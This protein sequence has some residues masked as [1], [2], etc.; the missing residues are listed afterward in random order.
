[1]NQTGHNYRFDESGKKLLED[2]TSGRIDRRSTIKKLFLLG[3]TAPAVYSLLGELPQSSEAVAQPF[4]RS[5]FDVDPKKINFQFEQLQKII[6]SKEV[7]EGLKVLSS[8]ND[9]NDRRRIAEALA[10]RILD[11][12][13]FFRENNVAFDP[14]RMRLSMRIFEEPNPRDAGSTGKTIFARIKDPVGI[15]QGTWCL[16]AGIGLCISYGT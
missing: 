6:S 2:Y 7:V 15:D 16:S 5:I 4:N 8:Q 11:D 13:K 14:T 9:D 1:M 12:P 3:F 10:S